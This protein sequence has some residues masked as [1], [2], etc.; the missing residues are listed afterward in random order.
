MKAFKEYTMT[1]FDSKHKVC[2]I[3]VQI[4]EA[5][6]VVRV[7]TYK[8]CIPELFNDEG[9]K[10][11]RIKQTATIND[12]FVNI[13]TAPIHIVELLHRNGFVFCEEEG[14]DDFVGLDKFRTKFNVYENS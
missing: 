1:G 13:S 7:Y 3:M 8:D 6:D 14:E 10:I 11:C 5:G 2:E 4:S 9:D 12:L